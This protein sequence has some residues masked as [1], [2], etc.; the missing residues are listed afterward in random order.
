MRIED[1]SGNGYSAAVFSNHRLLVDADSHDSI[2]TA[3]TDG[4][5]FRFCTGLITL[6]SAS[7][8]GILYVRNNEAA[9]L[10]I[11]EIVVR[12]NQ[13]TGG[14]NGV[15]LWEIFRNPTTGTLISGALAPA[16]R[17][18]TNFG[19]SFSIIADVF[20]GVEGATITDGTVYAAVNG[21]TV[22]QR[23]FLIET[24]GVIVPRGTSI[25]VRYTPPAGNTSI[26]I[27]TEIGAYLNSETFASKSA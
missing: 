20:K 26:V 17:A 21:L 14:A 6:T 19:S 18:N 15:G 8:S 7:P 11:S 12:M 4:K 13:S 3:A 5:A 27:T 10:I 1:G 2:I 22:P 25:A 16:T 23:V 24:A 9:N